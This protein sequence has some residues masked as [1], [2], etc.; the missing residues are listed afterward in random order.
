MLQRAGS[1]TVSSFAEHGYLTRSAIA[2]TPVAAH[3]SSLSA[4]GDPPIAE[5]TDDLGAML[6]RD[7]AGDCRDIRHADELRART[8]R[9]FGDERDELARSVEAE[10]WP[11]SQ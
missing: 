3:T 10:E 11:G 4:Q 8:V 5:T 6:D 9:K 2:A 1:V 7:G